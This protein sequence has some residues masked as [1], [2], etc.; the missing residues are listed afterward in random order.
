MAAALAAGDPAFAEG[1]RMARDALRRARRR[2]LH[3]AAIEPL[4]RFVSTG[5][6]PRRP[7]L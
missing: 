7:W 4:A 6:K 2:P 1:E 5:R 3:R